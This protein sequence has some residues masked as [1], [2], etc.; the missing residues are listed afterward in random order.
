MANKELRLGVIGCGRMTLNAHLQAF[1]KLK[2]CKI[3]SF[4]DVNIENAKK[5]QADYGAEHVCTNYE[6]MLPY[7]DA[8]FIVLPHKFHYP[9]GKFFLENG[10]HVLM[11]KPLA[12]TDEECMELIELSEKNNLKLMVAY[13][14]PYWPGMTTLKRELDSGK[15]GKIMQ[16]SIWTEQYTEQDGSVN[17]LGGGQLF[18]HGC[19]YI[20]LLLRFLGQPVEG[21]HMGTNTGTPWME[22]EGTSNVTIKFAN[23]AMGYHFG[24]WGARGSSHVYS[25]QVHTEHGFFEYKHYDSIMTFIHNM[26][27]DVGTGK[28]PRDI[29]WNFNDKTKQTQYELNHFIDCVLNDKQPLT[30]P[31]SALESN[32][33]IWKLYEA[34]EK[35]VIADLSDIK[36][37]TEYL[38]VLEE[39]N[40]GNQPK[41]VVDSIYPGEVH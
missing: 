20:D 26:G 1:K 15:Y 3:T 23:G 38:E 11:E 8:A 31:R 6:D 25:F 12:N 5:A 13:P 32:R 33:L 4:C 7:I 29:T 10:K 35:G 18:S 27:P 34:E 41:A 21:F 2:N 22:K 39:G 14:V 36:A 19:H 30:D 17:R 37:K 24:T 16:M 40:N 9:C 28:Y